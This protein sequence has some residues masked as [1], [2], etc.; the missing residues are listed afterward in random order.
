MTDYDELRRLAAAATRARTSGRTIHDVQHVAAFQD[1]CITAIPEL[2]DALE[3]ARKDAA[4]AN[5]QL[6]WFIE[7]ENRRTEHLR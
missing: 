3:A 6:D 2:L 5:R 4:E 7:R 1:A